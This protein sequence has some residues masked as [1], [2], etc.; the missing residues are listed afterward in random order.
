[1]KAAYARYQADNEIA[2]LG[3]AHYWRNAMQDAIKGRSAEQVARMEKNAGL[4]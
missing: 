2:S 4:S 3:D 1:M